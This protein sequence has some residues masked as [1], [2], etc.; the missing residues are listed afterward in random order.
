M[1]DYALPIFEPRA[2]Q[3][4]VRMMTHK[5]SSVM[6]SLVLLQDSLVPWN[7]SCKQSQQP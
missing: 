6:P 7:K 5:K 3:T 2:M 1:L 4:M